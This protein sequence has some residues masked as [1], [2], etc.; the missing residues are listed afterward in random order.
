M[1]I[2]QFRPR[3]FLKKNRVDAFVV[4]K[5]ENVRYLSGFTG[6]TAVLLITATRSHLITDSRYATQSEK[7]VSGFQIQVL[8]K[9]ETILRR[10]A[11]LL[12][13][14]KIDRLGFEPG[15]FRFQS[16]QELKKLLAP[17]RLVP[18][19]KGVE[20]LRMV[21][22]EQEVEKITH[23][24]QRAEKAFLTIRKQISAGVPEREIAFKME[25]HMRR[26]GAA[27]VAFDTIVASGD[28]SAMPHGIASDKKIRERELIIIDFGAECDGYFSDMTRTVYSGK[29]LSGKKRKIYETVREAQKAAIS[30]VKPGKTFGEIDQSARN[31]ITREGFGPY[32][33]HGTGHGIGLEVHEPP[34]VGP[35]N[36]GI[37]CE[38][39]I[40]TIEPGIYLPGIGGV[41]LEDM[42]LVE[43]EGCRLLTGLS[44]D[45][46]L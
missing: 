36:D 23:A 41:R 43:K 13:R 16:Y 40:F 28:R 31:W 12:S 15:D 26:L 45:W 24:V 25:V 27:R 19:K 2:G 6:S 29:R 44:R 37:I 9:G 30:A 46:V 17:I 3:P 39:M 21:K 18:L 34:Y 8:K 33:G 35:N 42:V 20:S 4:T 1:I 22:S 10:T 7:E 32:F 11:R 14:R 38:G 5:I